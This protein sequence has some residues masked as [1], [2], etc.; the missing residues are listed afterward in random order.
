MCVSLFYFATVDP[1][2]EIRSGGYE[3]ARQVREQQAFAP[4]EAMRSECC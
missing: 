1:A 4:C 3:C 2:H